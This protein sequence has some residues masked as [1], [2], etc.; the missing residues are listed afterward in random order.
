MI[1]AYGYRERK[2]PWKWIVKTTHFKEQDDDDRI[3]MP[4]SRKECTNVEKKGE[5]AF[6]SCGFCHTV[7]CGPVCFKADWKQGHRDWCLQNAYTEH[8]RS[9][10]AKTTWHG[11]ENILQS[12]QYHDIWHAWIRQPKQQRLL[13]FLN[14]TERDMA[15]QEFAQRYKPDC[16][17][18]KAIGRS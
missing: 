16:L 3:L 6:P 9:W 1:K 12:I 14:K 10:W 7:Y 13:K 11:F 5:K 15:D 17:S 4:C 2:Q 8:R 18:C